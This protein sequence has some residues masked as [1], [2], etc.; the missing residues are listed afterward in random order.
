MNN[1]ETKRKI[2]LNDKPFQ[3]GLTLKLGIINVFGLLFLT[4]LFFILA[5]DIVSNLIIKYEIVLQDP[6]QVFIFHNLPVM[7]GYF[8][9]IL[10]YVLLHSVLSIRFTHKITGPVFNINRKINKMRIGDFNG[11]LSL[12]S[13]DYGW[14]LAASVEELRCDLSTRINDIRQD[15]E[16]I[17]LSTK[18]ANVF[19]AKDTE[20]ELKNLH[21]KISL[22][23]NKL[24]FFQIDEKNG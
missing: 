8:L 19:L 5:Q 12:R 23:K 1:N 13:K 15:V 3:L 2:F 18:D 6:S 16:E 20:K 11:K 24:E 9:L 17:D 4:L 21:N 22:L 14:E 7:V 10:I